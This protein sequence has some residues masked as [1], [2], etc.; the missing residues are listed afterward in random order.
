M[1][2]NRMTDPLTDPITYPSVLEWLFAQTRSGA[3]RDPV[4]MQQ[5]IETLA[6]DSPPNVVHVVGTNGKGSVTAMLAAA[7]GAAGKKTGRFIS[8]H[9]ES[10][11]ERIS[12]D[13]Q[14]ISAA[15]VVAFIQTLPKLNPNPAFFELTLALTLAHFARKEVEVAVIEAGVGAKHDAT[16]VLENVRAV[17]ITNVGRDHLD[18]LGPTFRDVAEDKADAIRPGVPTLTGA[19]GEV[20]EVITEVA[21][22]RR[23]PLFFRTP[24]S[25]LFQLPEGLPQSTPTTAHNQQ[26]AAAALRLQG[27]PETAICQGLR[28]TLPA[29]AERFL[30]G[31]KEVL[32]D[33]AHNPDAARALLGHTRPP[34]VLLFGALPKKLGAETLEVLEP[35]AKHII[36]TNAV[37]GKPRS[38]Q[39]SGLTFVADPEAALQEA[40]AHCAKGGQVVVAGSFY[41]AGQLRPLLPGGTAPR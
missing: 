11:R 25:S 28:A 40:L 20:L 33:G 29:R 30:L 16:R 26:L 19:T 27:V 18:T 3:P 24:Q 23:S 37:P 38:L 17:I 39:K 12:V 36:L 15:E 13:G 10:F 9:V 22:R 7:Y 21:A 41:L 34:F 5:L 14:W 8:P 6:L 1:L 31:D 4:R 32:L 35:H 2:Q